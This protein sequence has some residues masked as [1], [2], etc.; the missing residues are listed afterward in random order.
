MRW[1]IANVC[2]TVEGAT[3]AEEAWLRD[4][5]SY[6]RKTYKPYSGK[7]VFE[8]V[9]LYHPT[10]HRFSTGFARL[11]W[12][13]ARELGH[14]VAVADERR[15]PCEPDAGAD[16]EWLRH[17]PS[18][19]G[20][21]THQIEAVQAAAKNK[22]GI[23]WMPTG[24]LAGDTQILINRGGGAR[25]FQ[26]STVVDRFN[27]KATPN[28]AGRW[29][30][31][32]LTIP[33]YTQS[34]TPEGYVRLNR[35]I[36][37]YD[38]GEQDLFLLTTESGR[39][40]RATTGHRFSTPAGWKRLHEI[41]P[42]DQ[43]AVARWPSYCAARVPRRRKYEALAHMENH[44]YGQTTISSRDGRIVRV[45]KHRLVAEADMNTLSLAE[46]IGRIILGQTDG[47]SFLTPDMAVH[48]RDRNTRN[49]TLSN[50]E[51]MSKV[52]HS[53][54][55]GKEESWKNVVGRQCWERVESIEACGTEHVFDLE[56]EEPDHNYIA[57]EFVVHN[58]GKTEIAI[59]IATLLPCRFLF[60]VHRLDLLQQTA[61][62]YKLRTGRPV[63]LI[64]DGQVDLPDDCQFVV[65][66][67]QTMNAAVR[68]GREEVLAI[69]RSVEGLIIDESHCLPASTYIAVTNLAVEAYYRFGLSGTP[70]VKSPD[71]NML[72]LGGLGPVI[73]RIR[74]DALMDI[75]LLARPTIR[76]V[77]VHQ[78]CERPTWH[79][80]YTESIVQ[81]K[82]RNAAVVAAVAQA[83]KPALVFVQR[84][85]H[86]RILEERLRRSGLQVEFT[87][88]EDD[89]AERR[90]AI[91]RLVRGD[92]E[93]LVCNVI[94]QEGVDIPS[95]RSVVVAT[96]GASP[97][98]ALQRIGRGMRADA[99]TDKT[100][101]EVW[102]FADKGCGCRGAHTGCRW[103]ERHAK[104][105]AKAYRDEGFEV[106][107]ITEDGQME[108]PADA[109]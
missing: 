78:L 16:L 3:D 28:R 61:D 29:C 42:G 81:S 94:F 73:Y 11:A 51:I 12:D 30:S 44:P 67:F 62:R 84:V 54:L 85:D 47:L 82:T 75:G 66:T 26:L 89:T 36:R 104:A 57:N 101:F 100:N 106:E 43:V 27:G 98:A 37:A 55:H 60:M 23:V 77:E 71:R 18:V 107:E 97:V 96:G 53:K 14:V 40:I 65:A 69:L 39:Q 99:K 13:K 80:A 64:G 103:L 87:W 2:T 109:A 38:N 105:R 90:A 25:V 50:L 46:F 76:M 93:V 35:I 52:E 33:T 9:S 95:L 68:R 56:M 72:T 70:M 74:P 19:K 41:A 102:D 8:Q 108:L 24:C 5:M 32:D 15:R 59:G 1:R 48:H 58:S 92:T 86:G 49:N 20:E 10:G 22:R 63:G 31:W 7:Y 79:G 45:P 6:E 34:M 88:G 21:I 83:E 17:H 91:Q 4:F